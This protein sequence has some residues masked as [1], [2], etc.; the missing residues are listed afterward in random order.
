MPWG[1]VEKQLTLIQTLDSR[2]WAG[3]CEAT[4]MSPTCRVGES[5]SQQ[6]NKQT[7]QFSN[8]KGFLGSNAMTPAGDVMASALQATEITRRA[9]S[10]TKHYRLTIISGI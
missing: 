7:A 10:P 8:L 3:F 4:V 1:H 2:N 6:S 5:K 9:D